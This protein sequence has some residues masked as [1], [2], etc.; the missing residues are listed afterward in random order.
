MEK[1]HYDS[2]K[3]DPTSNTTVSMNTPWH[4]IVDK[5]HNNT[6]TKSTSICAE[7]FTGHDPFCV[8]HNYNICVQKEKKVIISYIHNQFAASPTP[9]CTASNLTVYNCIRHGVG[10]INDFFNI[11]ENDVY[12]PDVFWN[13][14]MSTGY[15]YLKALYNNS[16]TGVLMQSSFWDLTKDYQCKPALSNPKNS[17]N[18]QQR[19]AYIDEWQT[20]IEGFIEHITGKD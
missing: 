13:L 19:Y 2:C 4:W 11:K 6:N 15:G 17:K 10:N 16:I 12:P 9:W 7:I 14:T 18:Q 8:L 5:N 1:W 20:N 3:D